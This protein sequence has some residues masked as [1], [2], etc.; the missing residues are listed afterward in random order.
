MLVQNAGIVT[1]KKFMDSPD[2]LVDLTFKV[3]AT[4][5]F[6]VSFFL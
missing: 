5:H 2:K 6:W 3:N 4:A 1:G